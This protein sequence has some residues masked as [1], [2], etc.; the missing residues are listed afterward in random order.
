MQRHPRGD[1]Y[2]REPLDGS[3]NGYE[4]P[5][6]HQVS[7]GHDYGYAPPSSP[8]HDETSPERAPQDSYGSQRMPPQQQ[9]YNAYAAHVERDDGSSGSRSH[10]SER[11]N[12]EA[13][14][15][16]PRHADFT[17]YSN[18]DS[19]PNRAPA[20]AHYDQS[21]AHHA[22]QSNITPGMDNFSHAAAG[23]MAGIAYNVADQ[24]ARESGVQAMRGGGQQ[25]P[26]PPS[27]SQYPNAS[28]YGYPAQSPGSN[29]QDLGYQGYGQNLS[30]GDSH[31]SLMNPFG[32]PSATHSPARSL[33]SFGN[34][35]YAD[36]RYQGMSS[37][38]QRYHDASLGVVNPN[39]IADDGD[40]G[41]HYAR[42]S[43]RA[44]MLS[45]PHSDRANRRIGPAAAA[46]VPLAAG[47]GAGAAAG[48]ILTGKLFRGYI[49]I[50]KPP[51]R[52]P[53]LT[54]LLVRSTR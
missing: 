2:E 46:A 44:S 43:N 51:W 4:T 30:T 41:L 17:S 37:H 48:G 33:R 11:A 25:L 3:H 26:P 9:A 31:S 32:T 19:Q 18:S 21:Y 49:T 45:L 38:A 28:N 15:P 7:R 52:G 27:R 24:N 47:A 36:D 6:H 23:G 53:L 1:P 54:S 8:Y 39:D 10:R 22:A 20:E 14:P 16:P 12:Q 5:P 50:F 29:A 34:E 13:A 42:R 35:P 40:D